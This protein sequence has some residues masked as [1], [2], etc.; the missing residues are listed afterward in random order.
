MN[1]GLSGILKDT[2]TRVDGVLIFQTIVQNAAYAVHPRLGQAH[3]DSAQAGI[4][5][6]SPRQVNNGNRIRDPDSRYRNNLHIFGR[7]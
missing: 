2:Q 4:L 5:K 3:V 7:P 1:R 6:P